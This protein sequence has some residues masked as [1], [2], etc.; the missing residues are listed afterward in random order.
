V[1]YGRAAP[2]SADFSSAPE[3][4]NF[5]PPDLG[6]LRAPLT[7]DSVDGLRP[8][9]LTTGPS[10][11]SRRSISFMFGFIV[12]VSLDK[13]VSPETGSISSPTHPM[14]QPATQKLALPA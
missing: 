14:D 5:Q 1:V 12:P 8:P 4:G 3:A 13:W 6:N 7:A 2:H 10:N 11:A 9:S